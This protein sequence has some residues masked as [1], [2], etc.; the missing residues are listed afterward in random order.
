MK[1]TYLCALLTLCMTGSMLAPVSAAEPAEDVVVVEETEISQNTEQVV[2]EI[3]ENTAED[4]VI[5]ESVQEETDEEAVAEVPV[6]EGAIAEETVTVPAEEMATVEESGV[7]E[8]VLTE[9]MTFANQNITEETKIIVRGNVSL[10]G[11]GDAFTINADT[12]LVFELG[13]TLTLNGFTNGFVLEDATLTSEG[14]EINAATQMDVFRLKNGGKLALSGTNEVTGCGKE[15]ITNRAIVLAGGG[16]ENQAVTLADG[17]ILKATNFFRGMETG[18]AKN[19]V[20]SGAG[21]ENS[22]FDFSGN[23]CGIALSYF[24]TNVLFK[25]CKLNVSNCITS[26]IFMR[27]DNAAIWGLNFDGV[28]IYCVNDTATEDIAVRFH[29]GPFSMVDSK[30][31]IQNSSI[32]GLW[33][34]DGWDANRTGSKIENTEISVSDVKGG[35]NVLFPR[36]DGK[37]ITFAICHDWNISGCTITMNDCGYAGIN[38]S[39]DTQVVRSGFKQIAKARMVGGKLIVTDSA[40]TGTGL[41]NVEGSALFTVQIGQFLHFGDD[42]AISN[43]DTNKPVVICA[44]AADPFIQW[45]GTLPNKISYDLSNLSDAV[46]VSDRYTL[47]GGSVRDNSNISEVGDRNIPVGESGVGKLTMLV[48]TPDEFANA[49]NNDE[50]TLQND[51]GDMMTYSVARADADGNRYI[52]VP[53]GYQ[54]VSSNM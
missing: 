22:T 30:V 21:M 49:S 38:L 25:D 23:E 9:G 51:A 39:N 35:G 27:Q 8:I 14:M 26:G 17:A 40:I 36:P 50:L 7:A 6:Q 37:A 47:T 54:I 52:W 44:K 20:I 41:N 48:I 31:T 3:A 33:I 34:Y 16:A 53:A 46:K 13:A 28:D 29:T 11:T 10:T 32:T 43:N 5:E 24:D 18:G 2:E 12:D 4:V 42:V 1:K 15:G 45:I 19:Y